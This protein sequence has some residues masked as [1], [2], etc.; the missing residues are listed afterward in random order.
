[1][2]TTSKHFTPL[3]VFFTVSFLSLTFLFGSPI[4]FSH[5]TVLTVLA[6]KRCGWESLFGTFCLLSPVQSSVRQEACVKGRVKEEEVYLKSLLLLSLSFSWLHEPRVNYAWCTCDPFDS[7]GRGGKGR[8]EKEIYRGC[9]LLLDS[10][11]ESES[12]SRE[13][14]WETSWRGWTE[15]MTPER[16]QY[17][18]EIKGRQ[19]FFFEEAHPERQTLTLNPKPLTNTLSL[20][21]HPFLPL[22]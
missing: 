9:L 19:M 2:P 5:L 8:G 11:D 6:L 1:M 16:N 21:R 7:T 22:F 4:W 20:T 18:Q 17:W 13:W 3:A 12:E 14:E 15:E 10:R